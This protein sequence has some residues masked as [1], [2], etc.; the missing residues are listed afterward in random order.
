[1]SEMSKCNTALSLHFPCSVICSVGLATPTAKSQVKLEHMY[2]QKLHVTIFLFICYMFYF[3]A[4]NC[5]T[6]IV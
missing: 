2:N 5:C 4:T 3:R 6:I 1:M